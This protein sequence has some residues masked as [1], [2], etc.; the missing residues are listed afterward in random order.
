MDVSLLTNENDTKFCLSVLWK[1]KKINIEY[2]NF[3]MKTKHFNLISSKGTYVRSLIRDMS[4]N[5]GCFSCMKFLKRIKVQNFYSYNTISLEKIE[6]IRH[7][8]VLSPAFITIENALKTPII[9]IGKTIKKRIDHGKSIL[10][11]SKDHDTVL[12]MDNQ[13]NILG[14]GST[15]KNIFQIKK[16]IN[17]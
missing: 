3:N 2:F 12:I 17:L 5:L 16:N 6:K 7:K 10:T 8:I 11:K 9:T 14:I 1:T 15:T 13:K 4:F